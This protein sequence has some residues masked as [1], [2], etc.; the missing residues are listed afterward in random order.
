MKKWG[1]G[2]KL[3]FPFVL[4]KEIR[5][6]ALELPTAWRSGATPYWKVLTALAVIRRV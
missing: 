1:N 6:F 3:P 2:K 5:T 4:S